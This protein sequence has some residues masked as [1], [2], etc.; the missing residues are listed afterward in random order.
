MRL[1]RMMTRPNRGPLR[2]V[3]PLV[4]LF[5]L[6]LTTLAASPGLHHA[7]HSDSD[8]PGHHCA[9][10]LLLAGQVE[11][12][13]GQ[14]PVIIPAAPCLIVAQVVAPVFSLPPRLLPPG[15]APPTGC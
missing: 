9:I 4:A 14:P 13:A 2:W 12:S 15:R 8:Q 5:F 11:P 10:T 6:L 7:I 1:K 3:S